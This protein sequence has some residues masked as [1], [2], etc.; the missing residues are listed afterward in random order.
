MI[1]MMLLR[2][3][4]GKGQLCRLVGW[5]ARRSSWLGRR[6]SLVSS[7]FSCR[8]RPQREGGARRVYLCLCCFLESLGSRPVP[9]KFRKGDKGWK[10]LS[11]RRGIA[12]R[13]SN[14]LLLIHQTLAL[15]LPES[16]TNVHL[17]PL[18]E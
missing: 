13:L 16:K 17:P 10:C 8:L 9:L 3:Y 4:V 2:A 7:P 18:P 11:L 15:P 14:V 1:L 12:D 5:L 6:V